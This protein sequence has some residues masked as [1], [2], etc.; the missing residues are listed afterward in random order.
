[1]AGLLSNEKFGYEQSNSDHTLFL[2]KDDGQITCLIIYVDDM[3]IT[4][5]N[6][7]EI[8]ELK[9][10]LFMEFEMK[11]LGNLKYFLGIEVFRSKKGIFI[12][13]NKYVLDLSAEVGMLD[14]KPAETPIVA[15][16]K[17]H[18]TPRGELADKEKY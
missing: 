9:K 15:N 16:H 7:R 17:L 5:N 10:K 12:N 8:K 11:D 4:G 18:T 3:V 2:K 13:Q 14:C 1:M 6:E